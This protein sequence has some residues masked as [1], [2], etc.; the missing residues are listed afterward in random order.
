MTHQ[1]KGD[2]KSNCLPSSIASRLD[3]CSEIVAIKTHPPTFSEAKAEVP[4]SEH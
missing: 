1:Q 3:T 2:G 4:T